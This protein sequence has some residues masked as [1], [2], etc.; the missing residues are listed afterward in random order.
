M[1]RRQE[2]KVE[3]LK[4]LHGSPCTCAQPCSIASKS[5]ICTAGRA[6]KANTFLQQRTIGYAFMHGST[7]PRRILC[8]ASSVSNHCRGSCEFQH[9]LSFLGWFLGGLSFIL[10]RYFWRAPSLRRF[11]GRSFILDIVLHQDGGLKT[12]N[13]IVT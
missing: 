8:T 4:V 3:S 5:K 13:I 9:H 12:F 7:F 1:A 6:S 11:L 2:A 10:L